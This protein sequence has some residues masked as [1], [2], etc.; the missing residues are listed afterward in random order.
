MSFNNLVISAKVFSS[1]MNQHGFRPAPAAANDTSE[2]IQAW[3]KI[4]HG[5]GCVVT[6]AREKKSEAMSEVDVNNSLAYLT[7]ALTPELFDEKKTASYSRMFNDGTNP[8]HIAVHIEPAD[9]RYNETSARRRKHLISALKHAQYTRTNDVF[10]GGKKVSE[11]WTKIS[12]GVKE[13]ILFN[14]Y[15][16]EHRD[17][18][19]DLL[20]G[21]KSPKLRETDIT[22][23]AEKSGRDT[24]V[25]KIT[26][27]FQA[28]PAP[29]VG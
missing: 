16:H 5:V 21:I 25:Y 6:I 11:T 13:T 12:P 23:Y 18:I 10:L 28:A 17:I 26:H 3:K 14:K 22:L 29:A 9:D 19:R 27:H 20:H 7:N 15:D 4:R 1:A 24:F 8:I 2:N